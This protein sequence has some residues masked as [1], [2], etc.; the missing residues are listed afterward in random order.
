MGTQQLLLIVLSVVIVGASVATGIMIFNN[1]IKSSNREAIIQDMY[2]ISS[3]AI[4]YYKIP[5]TQG[6][7]GG[8]W[9]SDRFMQYSGFPLTRNGKRMVTNNGQIRVVE[10]ANGRLRIVGFGNE[11]GFDEDKAIR[12]RLVLFG[13]EIEGSRF[14]ILN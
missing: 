13:R 9:D 12:A 11:L 14:K 2:N 6:G 8:S 3:L 10:L 4:A 5:E 1:K 7:G